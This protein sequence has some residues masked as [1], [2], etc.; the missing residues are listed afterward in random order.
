[1]LVDICC[2]QSSVS[3]VREQLRKSNSLRFDCSD[4]DSFDN[5]H[6]DVLNDGEDDFV[7]PEGGLFSDI[8]VSNPDV[9]MDRFVDEYL[10]DM[11]LHSSVPEPSSSEVDLCQGSGEN[12]VVFA[13]E[14][15][16]LRSEKS[17]KD[18]IQGF[19]SGSSSQ[20]DNPENWEKSRFM[21]SIQELFDDLRQQ[22]S[23]VPEIWEL[24]SR[25]Y[26]SQGRILEVFIFKILFSLLSL[27]PFSFPFPLSS[28]FFFDYI[29]FSLYSPLMRWFGL[30]DF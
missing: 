1:M 18:R 27:S 12:G 9:D 21:R 28:L 7:L 8:D 22:V 20:S 13:S 16:S 23:S 5:L 2:G 17:Q 3:A 30:F 6:D 4:V 24:Q 10:K 26:M 15:Y 11:V 14:F 25:M 29:F 19:L